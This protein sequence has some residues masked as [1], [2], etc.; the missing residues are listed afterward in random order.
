MLLP[1]IRA[2]V[3]G[4]GTDA[5]SNWLVVAKFIVF[6]LIAERCVLFL[7]EQAIDALVRHFANRG[8]KLPS[9]GASILLS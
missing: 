5:M 2:G 8:V 3:R 6:L 9:I 4:L 1:K 7:K